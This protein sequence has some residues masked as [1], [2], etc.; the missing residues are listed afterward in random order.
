MAGYSWIEQLLAF[1]IYIE[2]RQAIGFLSLIV[3]F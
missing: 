1:G 3:G 2:R